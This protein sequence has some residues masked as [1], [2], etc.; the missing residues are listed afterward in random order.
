MA[1]QN[2]N[3][4]YFNRFNAKLNNGNYTD[5]YLVAD[6]SDVD[7]EV[8]YSNQV[9]AYSDGNRLPIYIDLNNT[10]STK[11]SNWIFGSVLS[12]SPSVS[13]NYYN[14]NAE[15]LSQ[16]SF[17]GLCDAGLTGIDNGLFT[18]M[19]GQTL[20]YSMG[21]DNTK[22]F[23]PNYFDRRFKMQPVTGRTTSQNRFSGVT[24]QTLYNIITRT[25]TTEGQ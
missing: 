7:N 24:A 13:L 1:T 20:Y 15:N 16:Y 21:I 25:G 19:T 18:G 22:T 5:F 14:P 3:N 17:S 4:Y 11:K 6:E 2:I 23:E 10:S 9:I 8:I 12:G